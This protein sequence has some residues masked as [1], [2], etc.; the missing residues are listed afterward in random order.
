MK[1]LIVLLIIIG[2]VLGCGKEKEKITYS[3]KISSDKTDIIADYSDKIILSAEILTN[4]G[5]NV[6]EN[7]GKVSYFANN[8]LI[9]G[10]EFK[11][12]SEGV[13]IIKARYENSW[14]NELKIQVRKYVKEL[15]IT[16]PRLKLA[17]NGVDSISMNALIYGYGDKLIDGTPEYYVNDSKIAGNKFQ[18]TKPGSYKVYARL[19][20]VVSEIIN[21]E[22]IDC[23]TVAIGNYVLVSN[24]S[25]YGK[26][27]QSTGTITNNVTLEKL[28][29]ESKKTE[30]N[31][32]KIDLN[33]EYSPIGKKR[34]EENNIKRETP[35]IGSKKS[36][37]TYNYATKNSAMVE[38]TLQSI[39]INCEI[40]AED[41]SIV[42][43]EQA[44]KMALEFDQKI[45][46]LV[47]QKFYSPSDLDGNG[48]ISILCYDIKDGFNEKGSYIGGYFYARD[49]FNDAY[50]NK[51]EIFYIDT[52]PAMYIGGNKIKVENSYR[53]LVHEF[54]HMV[55]FNKICLVDN[56]K[57]SEYYI[58][59]LNEGLSQAAE[60]IYLG[61][62]LADRINC[63][64]KDDSKL[65][66]NGY[67][68]LE[69]GNRLEDYSLSYM[70]LQYLRIQCDG[71]DEF[72]KDILD[73]K[74]SYST[75]LQ[76]L[77]TKIDKN[78]DFGDY[79]TAFRVAL[80]KNELEGL[81]GFKGSQGFQNLTIHEY[82]G[83]KK[84]IPGGAS[85]L[86][87]INDSMTIPQDKGIDIKYIGF[88]K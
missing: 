3:V 16:P 68:L 35:A 65:I 15:V 6:T 13:Y 59:W 40:W 25:I 72:Y 9:T 32:Y 31:I 38:A 86:I 29:G 70:F 48:R 21:I 18:T 11:T 61:E 84:Y 8:L 10:N 87:P 49:L 88:T 14:S 74:Y 30:E 23:S 63:Y 55:N 62:P 67:S 7:D 53:T 60:Q 36:F 77:Q 33:I 4:K 45:H 24:E 83:S 41:T 79:M 5:N 85:V 52:Y 69:W 39:G 80:V 81:Y 12:D 76:L 37:W 71:G 47:T 17:A 75:L 42:T 27:L 2:A 1:K 58:T 19:E 66:A 34:I 43:T 26:D 44:K 82:T 57:G 28:I 54:Q 50:S 78:M 73:G 22:A 64:N 46:P 20:G 56:R 51:M